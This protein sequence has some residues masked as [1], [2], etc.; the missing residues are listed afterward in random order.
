[1]RY[2]F[3]SQ[4]S[5]DFILMF[6]GAMENVIADKNPKQLRD[7]STQTQVSEVSERK[8]VEVETQTDLNVSGD[9][10]GSDKTSSKLSRTVSKLINCNKIEQSSTESLHSTS[11]KNLNDLEMSVRKPLLDE[12]DAKVDINAEGEGVQN[13]VFEE[14]PIEATK[15]AN[16]NQV[17]VTA[18]FHHK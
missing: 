1:M 8:T 3:N 10:G 6:Q 15:T 12:M 2:F 18:D 17:E 5:C 4:E 11:P 14:E 7:Q 13:K 16:A 9:S